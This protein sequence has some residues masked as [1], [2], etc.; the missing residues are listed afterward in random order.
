MMIMGWV[1]INVIRKF[2][3]KH[4]IIQLF[5]G[6]ESGKI[7]AQLKASLLGVQS[8]IKWAGFTNKTN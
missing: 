5:L 8:G 4:N 2:C 7:L 3:I 6:N 1:G